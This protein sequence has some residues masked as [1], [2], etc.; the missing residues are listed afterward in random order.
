MQLKIDE[1]FKLVKSRRLIYL[2]TYTH[3][4]KVLMF[5]ILNILILSNGQLEI[6]LIIQGKGNQAFINEAFYSIPSEVKVN[7]VNKPSCQKDCN[8]EDDF[9]NV[10]I[11]FG[12][13]ITSCENK[14]MV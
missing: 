14:L 9:S 12:S 13:Y 11:K 4:N 7:G 2:I 6:S 1:L 10:T 3:L 5:L 8:F